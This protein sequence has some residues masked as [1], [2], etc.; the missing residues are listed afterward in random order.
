MTETHNYSFFGQK[1]GM[2]IQSSSQNDPFIF[3]KLLKK[4]QNV[5]EEVFSN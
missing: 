3:F 5:I 1:N 2:I 4:N